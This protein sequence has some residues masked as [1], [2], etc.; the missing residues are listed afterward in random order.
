MNGGGRLELI[1]E[2]EHS[3]C[4]QLGACLFG[5]YREPAEASASATVFPLVHTAAPT[6]CYR[7]AASGTSLKD[8]P[9]ACNRLIHMAFREMV[10]SSPRRLQAR[11]LLALQACIDG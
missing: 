1:H 4:A 10:K 11:C 6:D 3:I 8:L 7:T 5:H 9:A 2:F